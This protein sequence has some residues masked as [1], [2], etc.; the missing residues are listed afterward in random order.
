MVLCLTRWCRLNAHTGSVRPWSSVKARG[1]HTHTWVAM[2]AVMGAGSNTATARTGERAEAALWFHLG[3]QHGASCH[4]ARNQH[5]LAGLARGLLL[6]PRWPLRGW[7]REVGHAQR[8]N[9]LARQPRPRV[10]FCRGTTEGQKGRKRVGR[11]SRGGMA[12]RACV[13]VCGFGGCCRC[14]LPHTWPL[15]SLQLCAEQRQE[16]RVDRLLPLERGEGGRRCGTTVGFA[17]ALW[18]GG[19]GG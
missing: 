14:S 8:R 5:G 11:G 13:C 3:D 15:C 16:I 10:P 12:A 1:T 6:R 2:V 18:V 19:R 9:G 4:A 17:A 7:Q